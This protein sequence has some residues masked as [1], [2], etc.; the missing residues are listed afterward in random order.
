[1]EYVMI[2]VGLWITRIIWRRVKPLY[3]GAKG[4]RTVDRKLRGLK[5]TGAILCL[6]DSLF[7]SSWGTSQIDNIAVTRYGIIVCEVKNYEGMIHGRADQTNWK[8]QN[9]KQSYA[10]YNPIRQN[11]SHI[12]ALQELLRDDFPNMKYI[13]VVAFANSADL[14]VKGNLSPVVNFRDLMKTLEAFCQA[15]VLTD[16]QVK[17]V[18]SILEKN[19][20]RDRLSRRAHKTNIE[21]KREA[22]SEFSAAEMEA[23]KAEYRTL[24]RSAPTIHIKKSAEIPAEPITQEEIDLLDPS[25]VKLRIGGREATLNQIYYGA[26]R[27]PDGTRAGPGEQADHV[28]CPYTHAVLPLEAAQDL[29]RGLWASHFTTHRETIGAARTAV[30]HPECFRSKRDK[31]IFREFTQSEG[32][33]MDSVRKSPWFKNIVATVAAARAAG[34]KPLPSPV[35]RITG[36]C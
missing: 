24:A 12:S 14:K 17:K 13:P 4:E 16:D 29:Y 19:L 20:V 36:L 27:R 8:V 30:Q 21:F 26:L 33:F 11:Q 5:I 25:K 28:I 18:H 3:K 15:E 31:G 6:R 32:L 2:A 35:S 34:E 1:M 10:L 23:L 9:G 22:Q 7:R